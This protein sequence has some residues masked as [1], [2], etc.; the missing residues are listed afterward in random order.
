MA[1]SKTL[2]YAII[3]AFV[4]IVA[5]PLPFS[6]VL[7]GAV[8]A[9]LDDADPGGGVRIGTLAGI[10]AVVPIALFG[11]FALS[12]LGFRGEF[13]G[14]VVLFGLLFVASIVYTVGLSALGGFLGASLAEEF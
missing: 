3:G 13:G 12:F 6:T 8:A 2:P 4:S 11:Y 9:Y 1:T 5:A 14:F 10:I 7:G